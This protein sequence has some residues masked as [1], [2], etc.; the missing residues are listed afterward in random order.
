MTQPSSVSSSSTSRSSVT[1]LPE[2]EAQPRPRDELFVFL[3]LTVMLAPVFSVML[4]G[5]YG[6]M[7]WIA[8][9]LFGP[10][11]A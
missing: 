4:V 9:L 3:V 11:G 2:A 6:L 1:G 5:G 10:P 7:V 8:Q